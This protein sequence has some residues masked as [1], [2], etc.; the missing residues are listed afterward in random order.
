MSK[1][2]GKYRARVVQHPRVCSTALLNWF[3]APVEVKG[4]LIAP[5]NIL[6][7]RQVLH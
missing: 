6:L 2:D 7:H 4:A 3:L 5:L 1:N